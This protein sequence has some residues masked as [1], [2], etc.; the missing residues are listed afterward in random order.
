MKVSVISGHGFSEKATQPVRHIDTLCVSSVFSGTCLFKVLM[1]FGTFLK[2]HQTNKN[3]NKQTNKQTK[4]KQQKKSQSPLASHLFKER[5]PTGDS[6][7]AVSVI[8]GTSGFAYQRPS[9]SRSKRTDRVIS[10]ISLVFFCS[11][12]K[13]LVFFCSKYISFQHVS[14]TQCWNNTICRNL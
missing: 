8:L 12:K 7:N 1:P 14:Q 10:N 4:N 2:Q 13:S 5:K 3:K 9:C 6:Q 11:S